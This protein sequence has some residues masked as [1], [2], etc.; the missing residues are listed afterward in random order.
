M[1]HYLY[2]I[3]SRRYTLQPSHSWYA[4]F[5]LFYEPVVTDMQADHIMDS[6][7]LSSLGSLQSDERTL[8]G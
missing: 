3:A 5:A 1:S 2:R 6:N 7:W 4:Y 8:V